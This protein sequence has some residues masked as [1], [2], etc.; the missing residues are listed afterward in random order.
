[1]Q[2]DSLRLLVLG[3][4]HFVGRVV[5]ETAIERGFDVTLFNRGLSAPGVVVGAQE[6]RGDRDSDVSGLVGS[7]FDAVVDTTSYRPE[8]VELVLDALG[9]FGH[10]TMLSTL[11]V[12]RDHSIPG[13]DETAPVIRFEG[14][15]G[16]QSEADRYGGLK[17][18]C[19]E[20][21]E[22][23]LVD[24]ALVARAG[25]IVGPFD[26]T[27]RFSYWVHRIDG[28]GRVL[29]PAPSD[30]QV[31]F[32]DVRDLAEWILLGIETGVTGTFNVTGS[33]GTHSMGEVLETIQQTSSADSELIWVDEGLLVD[34]GVTPYVELPL[35]IP[36]TAFPEHRGFMARSNTEALGNGLTLRPLTETIAAIRNEKPQSI[37][38]ADDRYA[39]AGLSPKR[40]S[41]LLAAWDE[42]AETL[43]PGE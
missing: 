28:G 17:A 11:S 14:S 27:G 33:P 30:Q 7:R 19:E 26:K 29:A 31:Q 38:I 35:W 18:Q 21:L 2:D 3:G 41:E 32:I 37:A 43:E 25:L 1:M 4:T 36:L 5:A 9:E 12:Y 20:V 13:A 10:Y 15:D 8:Q 23:R 39:D 42:L 16:D 6:I 40:E 34:R 22:R 24:G